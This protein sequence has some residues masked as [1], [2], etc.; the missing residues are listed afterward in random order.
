ME[1]VKF[2]KNRFGF[3]LIEVLVFISVLGL[4][5]V[6]ALSVTTFSLKNMKI[7]EHKILATHYAEEGL[8][9][10]K[11]EKEGSWETFIIKDTSSGTGT[12]YCLNSLDWT[13]GN[14][15]TYSLGTP[16]TFKREAA[17][18]NSG[19]PTSQVN[20]EVVVSWI[21]GNQ[22]MNVSIKTIVNLWE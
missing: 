18:T 16:A 2:N 22:T 17:L 12:P 13:V 3:S 1:F 21:E 7:N 4:F 5:F 10:I 14:C 6:A 15:G 9:W 20:I 19:A 8:E 11:S